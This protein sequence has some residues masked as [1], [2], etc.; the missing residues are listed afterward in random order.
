[1]FSNMKLSFKIALGFIVILAIAGVIGLIAVF[2]MMNIQAQSTELAEAYVPE[3]EMANELERNSLLTMF[4]IRGYS[5]SEDETFLTQGRGYLKLVDEQIALAEKHV[6]DF[7]QLTALA[8]NIGQ[9][10]SQVTTY[11]SLVTQTQNEINAMKTL[12]TQMDQAAA[13]FV[14]ETGAYLTSQN[15]KMKEQIAS[16]ATTAELEDR[17]Q[18]ITW[19]NDIID[20]G[21]E[22]RVTNFKAQATSNITMLEQVLNNFDAMKLVEKQIRAVT[23]VDVNIRQLDQIL[24]ALG[25][26]ETAIRQFATNWKDLNSLNTQ[27]N[28]AANKVLEAAQK[29]AEG[30]I[31]Q[32]SDVA[33]SAVSAL[34]SSTMVVIIGLIIAVIVGTVLAVVVIRGITKP[35][36]RIV[37]DLN[38]GSDQVASASDQLSSASQQLAEGSSEQAS[39]LEETSATLNESTSMIQQTTENTNQASILAK[40]TKESAATGN[41]QMQEMMNSM[42]EIKKSSDEISKIIKVIDDIAFQ[43]NILSL[44]AAVEAARAGEAGA[45]FAVVAEEVRNLAQRSAQAA[46]DTASI[47]EKNI[48]LS[49]TGVS[50]AEKVGTALV[51]IN[52]HATK[53]NS[54]IDEINAASNEQAQGIN[55][56]NVAVGQMEEVTQGNA[57]NAEE[58]A[59]A[60]EELSAQAESMR[61][62]VGQLNK[63][64][65]GK[66]G[67]ESLAPT[68]RAHKAPAKKPAQHANPP[69]LQHPTGGNK[70]KGLAGG[71]KNQNIVPKRKPTGTTRVVNP[72]DVIPL[73]DDT[74]DF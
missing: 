20:M 55:Q 6:E 52:E 35:I 67:I 51:E 60:S 42:Q 61:E 41:S 70:P 23:K 1:M 65:T 14:Q 7:P 73:D 11:N 45:G 27:R 38:Q 13:L 36:S 19:I 62:I 25:Q 30:G 28:D 59:S 44:N 68:G 15:D 71:Q 43:T 66:E 33:N 21:N 57:A 49:Q 4:A 12:R 40:K 31:T 63:L 32:T 3:V 18:K 74:A 10:K 16:G 39:A 72:E 56:I 22:L 9:A 48:Q 34:A 64:V 17:L 54:L 24:V 50:V 29:V 53:V 8:N 58:S 26:Y 47:I 69:H 37:N 2:N 5:Y 46:K